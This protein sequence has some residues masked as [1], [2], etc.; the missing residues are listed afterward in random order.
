VLTW[1]TP[2]YT[3]P[4]R[5]KR[6]RWRPRP[7][8]VLFVLLGLS[9]AGYVVAVLWLVIQES[10]IVVEAGS[11]PVTA[12]PSLAHEAI[13]LGGEPARQIAWIVPATGADA[14]PWAIYLHGNATNI[15]SPVN[16]AHYRLLADL[17]LRVL[18]P[19]YRGFA[20]QEGPASE[21]SLRQDALTAYR[22][23]REARGVAAGRIVLYGW[24]LGAYLAVD[25]AAREAPG[26]VVLEAPSASLADL[27]QQ[28]YPFFPLRLLMRSR[29]E[30]IRRIGGVQAPLLFLHGR[31]DE[32]I[33]IS[34]ARE[35]Y[36]AARAEKLF[37]ET[38]GGHFDALDVEG[39]RIAQALRAFL[40]RHQLLGEPSDRPPIAPR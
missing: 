25:L 37:V 36:E 1:R 10:R 5:R 39:E 2:K 9:T 17:G 7:F 26:A 24:S 18:A 21:S 23:L 13:A 3:G 16:I 33:P 35:L 15:G 20:G 27:A 19:E 14:G 32:V 6:P 22:Y 8:R 34:S 12:P 28:R 31:E 30:S 4:E 29:F 38:R 40:T 11:A